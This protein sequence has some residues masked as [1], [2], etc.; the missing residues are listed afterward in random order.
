M[1]EE[2]KQESKPKAPRAKGEAK[3]KAAKAEAQPQ[4]AEMSAAEPTPKQAKPE[5]PAKPKGEQA[6]PKP[7]DE[8]KTK[9]EGKPKG[10]QQAKGGEGQGQA[11]PKGEGKAKAKPAEPA[12]PEEKVPP[13]LKERYYSEMLPALMKQFGYR[14][15]MQAPR[16]EKVVLNM[17]VGAAIQDAKALEGAMKDMSIISG[18][19]PCITRAKKSIAQF[20]LRKGMAVGCRVTLR[21]A[22][23]YE[24]LDRLFSVAL[25]RI[26]DFRGLPARSFDGRGNYTVGIREQLIFPEIN[27]EQTDRVRGMDITIATTARSDEE[28]R[29]LLTM[30]GLP[31]RES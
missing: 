25:P 1:A 7:E 10:E 2:E 3:P 20:R 31:L 15:V 17:G 27:V 19:R 23:M 29:A 13:R 24:F 21:G 18:Q 8:A 28:A 16:L 14:T 26:R 11:Q 30:M 12:P 6:E 22:R 9:G 5:K 4:Q